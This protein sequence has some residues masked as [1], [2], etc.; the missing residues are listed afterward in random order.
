MPLRKCGAF[1]P[2]ASWAENSPF[3]HRGT[4]STG[5][6]AV[7]FRAVQRYGGADFSSS[8]GRGNW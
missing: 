4:S 2:R 6:V 1:R 5:L 8:Y 7:P 3:P